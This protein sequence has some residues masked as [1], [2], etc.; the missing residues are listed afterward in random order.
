MTLRETINSDPYRLK[1][2][3]AGVYP[4][5][6]TNSLYGAVPIVYGHSKERTTGVFLL[7]AAQQFIDIS[8]NDQPK[9]SAHFLV[10]GGSLDLFVFYGPTFKQVVRQFVELTGKMH[11]PQLWTLGYHQCRYSYKTQDEVKE[12]VST[13]EQNDFPMD[14]IWLDIDYTDGKRYFT[15]N[16]DTFSDP[17]GMQEY[18]ASMD[19]RL[20]TII[21]P[22]FMVDEN[23]PVYVGAKGK[24]FAKT[25]NGDDYQANCW[26]GT[27]SYIDFLNPEARDYYASWFQFDK[28]NGST[29]TLAG[30]WNDMNEPAVFGGD[31]STFPNDIIHYGNVKHRDIHNMYGFLQTKATHQALMTRDN[32]LKRPFILTR[33]HFAGSQRYAAMWTGDNTAD[34]PHMQVTYSECIISGLVGHVF[35]GADIGGF[36]NNPESELLQRWYQAGVWLPFYRGH[37]NDNTERREPYVLPEDAQIVVRNAL[38]TR[39]RHLPVFYTLFYLHVSSGDP[40]VRP[41]FYEY[42][43]MVD[44][45]DHILLDILA[46]PVM[47][48]GGR[49]KT[50]H[51]PGDENTYW[52]R[53]DQPTGDWTVHKG[54]TVETFDVDLETSL[55][56]YRA[57]SIVAVSDNKRTSTNGLM[58]D[59]LTVHVN[60]DP[61]LLQ[62]YS[63]QM[64]E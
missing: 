57:G 13:M 7:N 52:Y 38:K 28:F 16:P 26:P 11:M 39:Y 58:S 2:V 47:E 33:S 40:V 56:F 14:A 20:V 9:A 32:N 34:W 60:L 30:I 6:S 61:E 35:C 4:A 21:D 29:E 63:I 8:Y 49:T 19:K 5:Y 48:Q 55:Y 37:A 51:F 46:A 25:E 53:A 43:E 45:D 36:F 59:R 10:E 3:D 62:D 24:Y 50:V 42:P 18:L 22:H 1:N 31:E 64:M 44:I 12:V 17:I 54:G 23:Y 41:L 27:S 15:W